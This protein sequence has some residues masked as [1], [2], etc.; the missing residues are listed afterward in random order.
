MRLPM[1]TAAAWTLAGAAALPPAAAARPQAAHLSGGDV[2]VSTGAAPRVEPTLAV[3]PTDATHLVGAAMSFRESDGAVELAAYVSFDGGLSWRTS[4]PPQAANSS[5]ADPQVAIT[6]AGTVLLAAVHDGEDERGQLS[7]D[8]RIYRS[9]DGGRIFGPPV[10]IA[11]GWDHEQLAVD[12]A[13]G[14]VYLAAMKAARVPGDETALSYTISLMRSDDDGRSF[15]PPA[16]V[17]EGGELG[18]NVYGLGVGGSGDIHV[19]YQT[20][21]YRGADKPR[22]D[23]ASVFTVRSRDG[24][25]SFSLPVKV[26]DR[27]FEPFAER[28]PTGPSTFIGTAEPKLAVRARADGEDGLLAVFN[29]HGADGRY[30]IVLA[31]S[32]DSGTSWLP[33]ELVADADTGDQTMP[34][35]AVATPATVALSWLDTRDDRAGGRYLPYLAISHDGGVSFEPPRPIATAAS[36]PFAPGNLKPYPAA[37]NHPREGLFVFA[38]S[39]YARYPAGGDYAGLAIGGDGV[40]HAFWPDSR[41]GTFQI[42]SRRIVLAARPAERPSTRRLVVDDQLSLRFDT[43]RFEPEHGRLTLPVRFVNRGDRPVYAPLVLVVRDIVD[44]AAM[45]HG[46]AE[47]PRTVTPSA[48]RRDDGSSVVDVSAALGDSGVLMPGEISRTVTW[49]LAVSSA[50]PSLM[51]R[52][53]IEA[54]VAAEPAAAREEIDR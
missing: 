12:P 39:T 32:E 20:F 25:R 22:T 40:V 50:A 44:R 14:S 18:V 33:A 24:G 34:S 17:V 26:G 5:A 31:R 49:V 51:M 36:R 4:I 27:R 45:A 1:L 35:I 52:L 7:L 54:E 41:D 48:L 42:Y 46:E 21:V 38:E 3:D 13:S 47:A 16:T 30:R 43:A 6:P 28:Q 37:V 53:R 11:G 29:Q 9:T 10:V 23:R 8:M 15:G 19:L 2:R